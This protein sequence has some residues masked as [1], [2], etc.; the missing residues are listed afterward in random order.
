M[1]EALFGLM[2]LALIGGIALFYRMLQRV[3]ARAFP[4]YSRW[5]VFAWV[6]LLPAVGI[7][8]TIGLVV[9]ALHGKRKRAAADGNVGPSCTMVIL[10]AFSG[11]LVACVSLPL[12]GPGIAFCSSPVWF[13]F[14]ALLIR[15]ERGEARHQA[16]RSSRPS[17]RQSDKQRTRLRLSRCVP[18]AAVPVALL[19]LA[20]AFSSVTA[21]MLRL[22][23]WQRDSRRIEAIARLQRELDW[24]L[25]TLLVLIPLALA[26]WIAA[27]D[28]KKVV[29]FLR[30]FGDDQ[31]CSSLQRAI[32]LHLG[33]HFRLLTLDDSVFRPVP[34]NRNAL[35]VVGA[36]MI[37]GATAL[38]AIRETVDAYVDGG[39]AG[40]A[41]LEGMVRGSALSLLFLPALQPAEVW[42][43]VL[44]LLQHPLEGSAKLYR[45][46][47]EFPLFF[48]AGF[49]TS[50]V[51]WALIMVLIT[52]LLMTCLVWSRLIARRRVYDQASLRRLE[53]YAKRLQSRLRAPTL[54]APRATIASV[55]D[56]FWQRTVL[57][58]T[59]RADVVLMDL[60]SYTEAISWE[61]DVIARHGLTKCV[62]IADEDRFK[63]WRAAAFDRSDA[64]ACA[65]SEL[66][67]SSSPILYGRGGI[68]VELLSKRL[69]IV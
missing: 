69:K 13:L 63:E 26:A 58:L 53:R 40:Y 23:I 45:Q 35:F 55:H 44:S 57:E 25:L 1:V 24:S 3:L 17:D 65:V 2:P 7:P 50:Y 32:R 36:G 15:G 62:F 46:E 41:Q 12:I 34:F 68:D 49:V 33:R 4:A 18:L 20:A 43:S 28:R 66:F 54:L 52:A 14:M 51:G 61:V 42:S 30:K 27:A 64:A 31:A 67:V 21:G 11:M 59:L 56:P 39:L 8:L 29:L 16:N 22:E 47:A 60:S 37:F 5:A 6:G 19:L 38:V 9:C 10:G 48:A